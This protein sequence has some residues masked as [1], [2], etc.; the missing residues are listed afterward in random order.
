MA[1]RFKFILYLILVHL[2]YAGLAVYL[3]LEHRIWLLAVEA[4]FAVTLTAGMKLIRSLFGTLDLIGTGTE[5]IGDGDFTTRFREVGQP[6]MDS[7]VAVYNKMVDHLREERTRLQEQ[8]YFLDKIV[9]AS[10]SGIVTFDFDGRIN[11]ANPAAAQLLQVPAEELIGKKLLEVDRALAAELQLLRPGD[12]R[13]VPLMGGRRVKCQKSQFLD[14]GFPRDFVLV[15]ELTE[16]LRRSE[17][18]A[19]EKLIRMMSH[20]VNNSI[21]SAN[22]LLHSC[23]N[24]GDQLGAEDR[25]DFVTALGVVISR[26]GQLNLFMRRF[27][28]VVRLPAP[29]LYL[30]DV[31]RL[32]REISQL[33]KSETSR[34]QIAWRWEIAEQ[35]RPILMD[36]GQME[37]VF[38]NIV[39]NAIEAIG[40]KGQITIRIGRTAGKPFATIED[41]GA[42]IAP[43]VRQYLFTPF[44]STKEN[45]QGIGL[46]LVQE[47]L[48][49]HRFEFSLES[50][51]GGPTQFTVYFEDR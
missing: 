20:E 45:G 50:P 12:S 30:C 40:E 49:R 34:R 44:F 21:G 47:I 4:L 46:T 51:A 1:L 11:T 15:E 9:T 17:K 35:L 29:S 43:E 48:D 24:Y 19:Y 10:P 36:K 37:Q 38:V 32:L 39:K 28:D 2:V 6:E 27:A 41:T 33:M 42:G 3:L 16:E 26:T 8:H 23:L 7:L 14:R 13:V 18:A 31:E 22:S 25:E 5:F